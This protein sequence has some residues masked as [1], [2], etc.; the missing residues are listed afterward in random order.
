MAI[1]NGEKI[2]I[3][4]TQ[5]LVGDVTGNETKFTVSF[6]EYSYVPDGSLSRVTRPVTSVDKYV[7]VDENIILDS[8]VCDGLVFDRGL[9]LKEV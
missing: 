4:F 8:G 7:S 3:K 1:A 9:R 5:P 6:D 2:A